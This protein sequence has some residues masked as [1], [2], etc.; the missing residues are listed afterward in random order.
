MTVFKSPNA[1]FVDISA[2]ETLLKEE[3]EDK[4]PQESK[5]IRH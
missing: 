2:S 3:Q 1:E 5:R 4:L